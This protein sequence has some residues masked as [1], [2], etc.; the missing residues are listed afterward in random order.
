MW[1]EEEKRDVDLLDTSASY[2][3]QVRS[4]NLCMNFAIVDMA[5]AS[6]AHP[7]RVNKYDAR[8]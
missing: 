8:V 5:G 1:K 4:L 6:E 2:V 7:Q 3:D